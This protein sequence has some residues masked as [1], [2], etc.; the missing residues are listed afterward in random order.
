MVLY[1]VL[2]R[3]DRGEDGACALCETKW[4][5]QEVSGVLFSLIVVV[6]SQ[7]QRPVVNPECIQFAL[8]KHT[9]AEPGNK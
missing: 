5:P 4:K 7:W 3:A 8:G 9:L 1:Y 2:A 6:V